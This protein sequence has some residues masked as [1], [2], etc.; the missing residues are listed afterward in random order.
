[1]SGAYTATL[2]RLKAQKGYKSIL[3]LKVLMW[4]MYSQRPL[5]AKELCHALGVEIGSADLD[6]ENVPALRTL[7]ASSLGLV[8]VEASSSTVRLVHFTLQ[9]H[10]SSDTT[11]F[12]N[13]HSAIAEVCLTYLNFGC[14]WDLS[15]T[16]H[17]A[18]SRTPL[19]EYASCYWGQHTRR[20]MT[21]NV[22]VLALRL[23]DG[24]DRHV[25][26]RLMLLK[27]K[28]DRDPRPYFYGMGGPIGYTGLHG[29]SFFGIGGILNAVLEMTDWDVTA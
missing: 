21:E 20:H 24:F 22:K 1:L 6:P 19:L 3:G 2:T 26:A 28:Q 18:P 13:P 27:Y 11:L 16:L 9:E 12:H 10:L 25:S 23:L 15:P 14:V 8:T 7:L 5:R 17:V 29:D 4:V